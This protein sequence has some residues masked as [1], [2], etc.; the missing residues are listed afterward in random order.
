MP[1]SSRVRQTSRNRTK[2]ISPSSEWLVVQVEPGSELDA[3]RVVQQTW[4][5]A[6]LN[7]PRTIP[8]TK[9]LRSRRHADVPY[10]GL[11]FVSTEDIDG[12]RVTEEELIAS[13]EEHREV[14]RGVVYE[15]ENLLIEFEGLKLDDNSG[16]VNEAISQLNKLAFKDMRFSGHASMLLSEAKLYLPG[17][18]GREVLNEHYL[19]TGDLGFP[20]QSDFIEAK[21]YFSNYHRELLNEVPGLIDFVGGAQPLSKRGAVLKPAELKPVKVAGTAISDFAEDRKSVV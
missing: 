17:G 8:Q 19:A 5:T 12:E 13:F 21:C 18:R 6:G 11:I 9:Q 2:E 16:S 4:I 10:R 7:A 14:I 20:D 15:A 1:A 3:A